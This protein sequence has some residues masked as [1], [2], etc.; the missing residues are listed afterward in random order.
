MG[1]RGLCPTC[2]SQVVPD[3]S[4]RCQRCGLPWD[5]SDHPTCPACLEAP[6][7]QQATVVWGEHDGTLRQALLLAKHGGHDELA[8]PLARRMAVLV[9]SQPWASEVE[10][11]TAVP[12][13]R[14]RALRRGVILAEELTRGIADRLGTRTAKVLSRHGLARQSGSSR[15]ARRALP[16]RAFTA[17]PRVSDRSVLLVDDV[18]TTG[19]T[20]RR[21]AAALRR[22]GACTV[23]CVVL[24]AAPDSRRLS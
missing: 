17:S 21:A 5:V 13:H 3:P 12:T 19:T 9:A 14:L 24:A 22:S 8:G 2:W 20:L 10:L 1:S 16:A 6:P 15:A 11:V 23:Y 4:V 7:P 18:M